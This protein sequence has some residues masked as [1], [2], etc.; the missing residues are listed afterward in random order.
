MDRRADGLSRVL[1]EAALV[2]RDLRAKLAQVKGQKV[3]WEGGADGRWEVKS[4]HPKH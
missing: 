2:L 4:G 3:G 1:T